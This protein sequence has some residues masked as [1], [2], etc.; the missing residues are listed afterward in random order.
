MLFW[1]IFWLYFYIYIWIRSSLTFIF[2]NHI[3]QKNSCHI[4]IIIIGGSQII[5]SVAE[6]A[7]CCGQWLVQQWQPRTIFACLNC[8]SQA[9]LM[10]NCCGCGEWWKDRG[11]TVCF[12][13]IS[14]ESHGCN[15]MTV[16]LWNL[17]T[18]AAL[19]CVRGRL[20]GWCI[21][22]VIAHHTLQPF[23]W[24]HLKRKKSWRVSPF[25]FYLFTTQGLKTRITQTTS[26][27]VV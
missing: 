20:Q 7:C 3:I 16:V 21:S 1:F 13:N 18:A 15:E 5:V 14:H 9:K 4:N 6:A 22:S 26:E 12:I 24:A 2:K 10:F 8:S 19:W 27:W 17:P 25:F 23:L 11:E